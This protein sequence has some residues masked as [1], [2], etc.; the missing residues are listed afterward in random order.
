MREEAER[1]GGVRL[2]W[3]LQAQARRAQILEAAVRLFAQYGCDGT[4]TRQ[5]AK[6]LH[7]TEG[8]IFHYF[9]TKADLLA[10]VLATRGGI[11]LCAAGNGPNEPTSGGDA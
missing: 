3:K 2:T 10:A 1:T 9:P 5:I 6:A 8:L 7:I 4:A 11:H